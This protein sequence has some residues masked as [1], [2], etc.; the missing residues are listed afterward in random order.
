MPKLEEKT[1]CILRKKKKTS[2]GTSSYTRPAW[3]EP[4]DH[5]FN[6]NEFL[7]SSPNPVV[8]LVFGDSEI[9]EEQQHAVDILS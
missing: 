9:I 1:R 5:D 7:R 6:V 2:G 4:R 8:A 3:V